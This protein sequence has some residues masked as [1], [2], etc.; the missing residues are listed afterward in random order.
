LSIFRKTVKRCAA[1][2]FAVLGKNVFA[3]LT[4]K[5]LLTGTK[6]NQYNTVANA[7]SVFHY[8][9]QCTHIRTEKTL[10]LRR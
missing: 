4:M 5:K 2:L 1:A 8:E 9:R 10:V 3:F 6:I 7:D